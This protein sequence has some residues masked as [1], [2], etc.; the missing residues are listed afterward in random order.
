MPFLNWINHHRLLVSGV[1][2][3]VLLVVAVA[4][5]V[6]F[7]LLRTTGT[8]IDLRQALRLYRQDER[9]PSSGKDRDLPA[10]GVYVYKTSGSE[11]LSLAGI[12]RSFPTASH[13]IVTDGTCSS[14]DWVPLVQHTEGVVVCR[15]SD[16]AL[17]MSQASSDESIAGVSTTQ[18]AHCSDT[19]YFIPPDP[20]AGQRWS[21]VC[22]STG[23]VD[24]VSG[25]VIGMTT[26]TVNGH[27][28][29]A[30]HTRI[31]TSV[32]GNATGTDPTDYWVSPETGLIYRQ[33]EEVSVS[34]AIGPLGSVHYTEQMA[35]SMSSLLPLK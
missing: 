9:G 11:K 34:Q 5:G 6:W 32:S 3:A 18:V 4:G 30:L 12:S 10:P 8:Q 27:T 2:F 33:R 31:D 19:S 13:M 17:T 35:I 16:G 24:K 15:Q 14:M 25:E 22:H 7:F 21:G 1:S 26:V 28:V 23:Q 20:H 29:P